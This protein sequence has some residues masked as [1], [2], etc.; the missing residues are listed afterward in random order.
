MQHSWKDYGTGL[1]KH[2]PTVE[3]ILRYFGKKP[4]PM[5]RKRA[6]AER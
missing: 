4:P 1:E 3:T 6:N 5:E 2:L